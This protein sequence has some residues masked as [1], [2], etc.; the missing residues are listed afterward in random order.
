MKIAIITLG[1]DKNTVD[2][3]YMAGILS[4]EN[5]EIFTQEIPDDID[6]VIINTC[7]FIHDAKE[8]SIDEIM[9][10]I[11]FKETTDH[12]LKIVVYGCLAQ[13]Y[14]EDILKEI[15]E[16][17]A[18]IGVGETANISQILNQ[19]METKGKT[20]LTKSPEMI[21]KQ[22]IPRQALD[23]KPYGFLKISDGCDYAC[24]FCAIPKIKGP[25]RS[26]SPQIL[27]NEAKQL[28][29][30]GAKE[31]NIIAQD[32]GAYG[33]DLNN[34]YNLTKLLKEIC[35]L[36]G[37]FWVRLFYLY[38]SNINDE[39][40]YLIANEPKICKYIDIPFQHISD[41]ILRKMRRQESSNDIYDL[42]EK[43]RSRVKGIAIRTTFLIGFPGESKDAFIKLTDFIR[44]SRLERFGAF[45]YSDEEGTHAYTLD[46]KINRSTIL[47]RMNEFN[48]LQEEIYLA[49]NDERIDEVVK[50]LIEEYNEQSG[51]FI[52]RSQ[53]EAPDIDPIILVKS[54]EELPIGSFQ[55]CKIID[56]DCFELYAEIIN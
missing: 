29:D 23:E 54:D 37:D 15:P 38:P 11:H 45:A 32:T 56:A 14:A 31:I 47:G 34:G 3:E 52:A 21:I 39:L 50:V 17:D 19:V 20:Y 43:L 48:K 4:A 36:E 46:D 9:S 1:C 13:R 49:N 18:V 12:K 8:Q 42:I 51:L 27:L 33:K 44:S 22:E 10:W 35:K 28:L 25:Y 30:R 55:T 41:D 5:H 2:S 26:V 40:I 7:G 16:I 24:S 53:S 6:V